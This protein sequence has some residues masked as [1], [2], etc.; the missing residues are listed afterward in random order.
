[1]KWVLDYPDPVFVL[2]TVLVLLSEPGPI[3]Y[4]EILVMRLPMIPGVSSLCKNSLVSH[5]HVLGISEN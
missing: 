3:S 1:M 5:S 2:W 4:F